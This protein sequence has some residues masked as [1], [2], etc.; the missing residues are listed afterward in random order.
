MS[1]EKYKFNWI[2]GSTSTFARVELNENNKVF[3]YFT[4]SL[5]EDLNEK[6]DNFI[7]E[8]DN[9][10]YIM[11]G[12]E[13]EEERDAFVIGLFK[14]KADYASSFKIN[15]TEEGQYVG[16]QK[17]ITDKEIY[18]FLYLRAKAENFKLADYKS[19]VN[20]EGMLIV[21]FFTDDMI[22]L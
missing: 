15:T 1:K 5:L 18:D 19:Y 12:V 10:P 9:N 6:H 11:V 3:I 22:F 17:V 20:E 7:E 2:G 14:E 4:S 8:A 16:K 13:N 21:K